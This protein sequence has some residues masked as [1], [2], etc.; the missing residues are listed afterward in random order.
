VDF[1]L[2]KGVGCVCVLD[3]SAAALDKARARL[4]ENARRVT[5]IEADVTGDWHVPFVDI[6]HDRAVFHFLTNADDRVRYVAHLRTALRPGGSAIIATFA[7]DGP[8]KCSGLPWV[9]YSPDS[10]LRELG[11]DFDSTNGFARAI[12]PRSRL[13]RNSD[14]S[15]SPGCGE[16]NGTA[17]ALTHPFAL[18]SIS[19]PFVAPR[20]SPSPAS[21]ASA[22]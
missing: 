18:P 21:T 4:G 1:V 9:R 6:W 20:K 14:T 16:P 5:W 11:E 10:L 3:I 22:A 15:G 19:I 7:P 13:F 2:S 8:E 12:R 17:R